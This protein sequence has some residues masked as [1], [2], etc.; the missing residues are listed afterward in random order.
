LFNT[1]FSDTCIIICLITLQ[2]KITQSTTSSYDTV[3]QNMWCN[4]TYVH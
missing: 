4:R 2:S 1:I 3:T